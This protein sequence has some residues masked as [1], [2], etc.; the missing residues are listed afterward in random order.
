MNRDRRAFFGFAAGGI[1]TLAGLKTLLS[2]PAHG[3][4]ELVSRSLIGVGAA[5]R[6]F[7]RERARMPRANGSIG[8]T[9][10]GPEDWRLKIITPAGTARLMTLEEVKALPQ[11]EMTPELMCVEGWSEVVHWTGTPLRHLAPPNAPEYVSLSTPDEA[12]YVGLDRESALHPQTLLAWDMN[13]SPLTPEHGAPLR[14][15]IP[16][17]YGTKNIKRIGTIAFRSDRPADYWAER[18]Y[19]WFAGL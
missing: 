12:Y 14:L 3:W 5:A 15:V 11:V 13:G 1:A 9:E 19:D 7:A 16:V 8:L 17:K 10:E 4:N 2:L 18:G 6:T